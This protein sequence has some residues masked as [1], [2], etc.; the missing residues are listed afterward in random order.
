MFGLNDFGLCFIG[1]VKRFCIGL[2]PAFFSI[3]FISSVEIKLKMQIIKPLI[4]D[5]SFLW[6]FCFRING[7]LVSCCRLKERSVK[8]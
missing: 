6:H 1:L 5:N 7:R 2:R 8:N 4:Y 3:D